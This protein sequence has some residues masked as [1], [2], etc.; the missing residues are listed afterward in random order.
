M[1]LSEVGQGE[2]SRVVRRRVE[3]AGIFVRSAVD[4]IFLSESSAAK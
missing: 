4:T 3:C 1:R 2:Q